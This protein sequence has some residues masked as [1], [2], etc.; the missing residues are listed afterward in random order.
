MLGL[1][2]GALAVATAGRRPRP[3]AT[4][5]VISE[6]YG[7]G[8]NSGAVYKN[9]F[10]ELY[11]PTGCP[12]RPAGMSLQYRSATGTAVA[13]AGNRTILSGTIAAGGYFLVQDGAP[14]PAA[15]RTCPRPTR[16][17]T[18]PLAARGGQVCLVERLDAARPCRGTVVGD[19]AIVDFVGCG[20]RRPRPSRARAV[21]DRPRRQ[22]LDEPQRRSPTDTDINATDFK[23]G[24]VTP[25]NSASTAPLPVCD[26]IAEIQGTGATRRAAARSSPSRVS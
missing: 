24:A 3:A 18:I 19:P 25:R 1:V 10:V 22:H 5:V 8:G 11:N 21:G 2:A 6:V 12:D 13:T 16:S 7:G 14:A 26:T 20:R 17:G 23:V 9:D 4:H 15:P